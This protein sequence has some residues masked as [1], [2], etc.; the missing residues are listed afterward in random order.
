MQIEKH[1]SILEKNIDIGLLAHIY[2]SRYDFAFSWVVMLIHW[3]RVTHICVNEITIIGS[4]NGMSLGQRQAIIWWWN[5]INWTVW[6]KLQCNFN[7]NSNIFIQENAFENVHFVS[8][9]M[10]RLVFGIIRVVIFARILC[11]DYLSI[12][13]VVRNYLQF[14][15]CHITLEHPLA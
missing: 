4:D 12:N 5:I 3:R 14:S 1:Y 7:L 6:N 15:G 11:I 2:V 10:W 8:A 9:P 13:C